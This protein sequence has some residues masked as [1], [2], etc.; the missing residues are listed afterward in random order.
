MAMARHGK[1]GGDVIGAAPGPMVN[2][3]ALSSA[4]N[5]E[6]EMFDAPM[7][8]STKEIKSLEEMH[9]V[10]RQADIIHLAMCLDNKPYV[11][12]LNFGFDGQDIYFHTAQKGLKTDIITQNPRVCFTACSNYEMKSDPKACQWSTTFE[13][14]VG[15]GTAAYLE[16]ETE[17][18][19]GLDAVMKHYDP[20]GS[21]A[22][23]SGPLA[24]IAVVK[25]EISSMTGKKSPAPKA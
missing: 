24:K 18:I 10:L 20:E 9:A 17:K 14:V 22:Y 7:R 25:I 2:C 11:V 12:P 19:K 15:F 4:Q 1:P 6:N 8:R 21:P 16:D 3:A 23:D 5:K 13:S